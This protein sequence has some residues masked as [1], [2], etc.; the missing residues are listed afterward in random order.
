[1]KNRN[2]EHR[3]D[4]K[5]PLDLLWDLEEEFWPMFD[6]C[7]FMHDTSKWNWLEIEWK[8]V[9]FINPPYSL[10]EKEAF[11]KKAIEESKKWKTCVMLLPVSTS[12][13]LF[14]DYILPNKNEIRFLKGRVKFSWW[15][16]KWEWVTNKCW[17]HDSMIVILKNDLWK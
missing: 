15:N 17:M 16:T 6:P 5:T 3:N 8:D 14:H 9:N 13:K 4:W 2:L 11:V 7:P 1:M 12:T 10:K